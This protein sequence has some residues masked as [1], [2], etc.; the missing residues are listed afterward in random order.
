MSEKIYVLRLDKGKYYIGKTAKFIPRLQQHINKV[1]SSWT[2]AYPVVDVEEIR[3]LV[4]DHDENNVTK[5]YMAKYGI[6]NVR[7]GAYVKITLDDAE[8]K[9][10]QK[11]I[12]DIQGSCTK[13]GRPGHMV[14]SCHSVE[15]IL[16]NKLV[17]P[18]VYQMPNQVS[19]QMSLMLPQISLMPPQVSL[20]PPQVSTM[21]DLNTPSF[22]CGRCD[23]EYKTKAGCDKH[24][25][26]CGNPQKKRTYPCKKCGQLGHSAKGCVVG[27]QTGSQIQCYKC[28]EYGHYA[29]CCK[30]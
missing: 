26:K 11:E 9:L 18:H 20:I 28:K 7:G 16:G 8:K 15:D 14:A 13:C 6:D 24:M 5:E 1:A 21:I 25:I 30:K 3:L 4:S 10:L 2:T 22:K 29:N 19:P 27:T 23:K 17:D 12:W